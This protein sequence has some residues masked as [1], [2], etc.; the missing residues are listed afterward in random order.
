MPV[1]RRC[2]QSVKLI[3][4]LW[5]QSVRYQWLIFDA[6]HTLF[7]FD[8]SEKAALLETLEAVCLPADGHIY[9]VYQRINKPL[10]KA[11]EAGT[12]SAQQLKW[13]RTE[14]LLAYLQENYD[15]VLP[16]TGSPQHSKL[17]RDFLRHYLEN[18]ASGVW[19]MPGVEETIAELARTCYMMIVTNGIYSMQMKRLQNSGIAPYFSGLVASD[20]FGRAK[21]EPAIFEH[22]L[23]YMGD[24][25][26]EKVLVIGDKLETDV[27][28]AYRCGLAS[29]WYNPDKRRNF[30]AIRPSCEIQHFGQLPAIVNG[31]QL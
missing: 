29:C 22:T 6:D 11:L 23:E 25:P 19:L 3:C 30:S 13:Q 17:V 15:V 24:P 4:V 1:M 12:L 18:L 10:W 31:G 9:S 5:G 2:F 8:Q 21:P 20:H 26:R 14:R 7:D 28:G 16:T 27:L